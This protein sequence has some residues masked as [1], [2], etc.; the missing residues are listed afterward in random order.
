MED[1]SV[2]NYPYVPLRNRA[3]PGAAK[4]NK[5]FR[6][7]VNGPAGR[8]SI[9]GQRFRTPIRSKSMADYVKTK[10]FQSILF[11]QHRFN[12][13]VPDTSQLPRGGNVLRIVARQEGEAPFAL[14]EVPQFTTQNLPPVLEKES[15]RDIPNDF[16]K[17][18]NNK[19]MSWSDLQSKHSN[20]SSV[21]DGEAWE[22]YDDE[23]KKW[24]EVATQ[25]DRPQMV[26]ANSSV[27][28]QMAD[29][30]TS[31]RPQMAD[32]D[33]SPLPGPEM[34][35]TSSQS[36]PPPPPTGMGVPVE[37]ASVA[38]Q[39]VVEGHVAA[40]IASAITNT[41][42]P[43]MNI[44][45]EGS[46]Y[47][48]NGVRVLGDDFQRIQQRVRQRLPGH[49]SRYVSMVR[50]HVTPFIQSAPHVALRAL[51]GI[52]QSLGYM[53]RFG[54]EFEQAASAVGE[55]VRLNVQWLILLP[56][57]AAIYQILH[58]AQL[59]ALLNAVYNAAS[60]AVGYAGQAA[61]IP[62]DV[63]YAAYDGA[64]AVAN[65]AYNGASA[66]V[67]YAGQAARI[68][69][70]VAN[71][72]YNG[73]SNVADYAR[74]PFDIAAS[75]IRQ[76]F[77]YASDTANAAIAI[78][79]LPIDDFRIGLAIALAAAFSAAVFF[80]VN[81]D[82]PPRINTSDV[83]I[84]SSTS[85]KKENT[86][87]EAP[88]SATSSNSVSSQEEQSSPPPGV[89]TRSQNGYFAAPPRRFSPDRGNNRTHFSCS[90]NAQPGSGQPINPNGVRHRR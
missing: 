80:S 32:A 64:T 66:A 4:L 43:Y 15:R 74:M 75:G 78:A 18:V 73:V 84:K 63:A 67:G 13:V 69:Y 88:Q 12:D 49:L 55:A 53:A 16:A 83:Y 3:Q 24:V 20:A 79:R 22:Y 72:A 57:G 34:V 90:V 76:G 60:A 5:L 11:R 30:D 14:P 48:I 87:H 7:Q 81:N 70:N 56:I 41:A 9:S 6:L 26:D 29:A 21:Y 33:T 10:G 89:Q 51:R 50:Q 2:I 68:P 37:Q 40:M 44:V 45:R 65:A 17:I 61:S 59:A 1:I 52:F 82:A 62:F 25:A 85:T 35:Q 23:L 8:H 54:D 27:R 58:S 86:W 77:S 71:A 47:I 19:P 42:A 36:S 38:T 28:P 39:T 31:V 46:T